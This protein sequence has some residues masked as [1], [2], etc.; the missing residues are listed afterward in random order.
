M[1]V[2][3]I[4]KPEIAETLVTIECNKA[5]DDV[6]R[7]ISF[8]NSF[9]NNKKIACTLGA[10]TYF[11]DCKD[12]LYFESVDRNTYCYTADKVYNTP[13]KLYEIEERYIAEDFFRISKSCIVNISMIKSI[14]PDFASKLL[15]TMENGEKIYI[16]RQYVHAFKEKLGISGGKTK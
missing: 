16:S 5:D 7:L 12:V 14:K 15:A 1:K 2:N 4:Q 6:L 9:G 11:I 3:M 13:L 10:E 8:I